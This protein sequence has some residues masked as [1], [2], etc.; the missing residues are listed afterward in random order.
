MKMLEMKH[1]NNHGLLRTLKHEEALSFANYFIKGWDKETGSVLVN[2]IAGT[3]CI[4]FSVIVFIFIRLGIIYTLLVAAIE[5]EE[6]DEIPA[7]VD[8][9]LNL[10]NI[11]CLLIFLVGSY[12]VV[13]GYLHYRKF[14]IAKEY[15]FKTNVNL[16]SKIKKN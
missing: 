5:S 2:L 14:S 4:L 3:F 7:W 11:M 12:F 6:L 16:R 13:I 9:A 1:Q 8:L 15:M 10:M